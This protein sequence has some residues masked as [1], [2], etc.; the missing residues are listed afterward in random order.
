MNIRVAISIGDYNGIGPEIILKS[1]A[2]QKREEITPVIIA[3]P[4]I[5]DYYA[6]KMEHPVKWKV[7]STSHEVTDGTINVLPPNS[8][9]PPELNPGHVTRAAGRYA[10]QSVEKAVDLCQQQ[11]MHAMVT[12]PISKEAINRAGYKIPGHTEFLAEKTGT[13]R[14]MMLLVNGKL[15]VGLVTI[16]IPLSEV[17]EQITEQN[18]FRQVRI[19]ERTLR[20]DFGIKEPAIAT[21]GLNPHAGDGG[22]IGTEELN[23]IHPALQKLRMDGIRV[24]GPFP[25][26]AFF[27]NR[28]FESFDGILAMYHDQGLIPFKTL[29][30]GSGVNFTAGLPIIRTSP[31]HGTAFDIAGKNQARP[32]SFNEA[33]EL[34]VQLAANRLNRQQL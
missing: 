30:F 29:S 7:I 2:D 24:E 18:I 12:A 14:F 4:G 23:I 19:M 15:R 20:D 33:L 9:E 10:M 21:L 26:D 28:R 34:A 1:L 25:A 6:G 16:H 32:D 3:D 22:V 27:G 11:S 17:P 8:E 5:L 13:P 31:D